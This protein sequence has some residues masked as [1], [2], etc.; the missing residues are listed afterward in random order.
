VNLRTDRK[1]LI[2]YVTGGIADDWTDYVLAFQEAGADVIEIGLPFSDPMLDGVT[3]QEASDRALARGATVEGILADVAAIRAAVRVPMVAMTYTNLVI[4][5]G[6]AE[7]CARLKAAGFDGLIVPDLPLDE[8]APLEAAAAA[9]GIALT[10]L[11]AP[12]TSPERIAEICVRSRGY[13]YAV[14]VMGTTGER[15]SLS[16]TAGPLAASLKEHATVPVVLGFGISTPAQARDA[17]AV[18][19][20]V[21]IG[22]ALMRR[23]LDGASAE[24]VGGDLAGMRKGMDG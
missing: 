18:A 21:A 19:D 13:I 10:L 7:F 1:L 8:V 17:G 9:A 12:S 23:V 5:R 22:A 24:R 11:A 14:S 4:H 20:G 3:I 2:P 16:R 15:T 6:E